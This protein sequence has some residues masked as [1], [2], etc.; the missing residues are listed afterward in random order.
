[1]GGGQSS[2]K[3]PLAPDNESPTHAT[4]DLSVTADAAR[5]KFNELDVDN[6]GKLSK[7]E[8]T[9]FCNWM[10][11][12]Y[13]SAN[14]KLTK[15]EMDLLKMRLMNIFDENDD[16]C[17]TFDEFKELYDEVV[18][19]VSLVVACESKFQ[20]FDRDKNGYLEKEEML[21][22][23][24]WILEKHQHFQYDSDMKKHVIETLV[25]KY[26]VNADCRLVN[27]RSRLTC[28]GVDF[29]CRVNM[30]SLFFLRKFAIGRV[31]Y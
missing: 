1:M 3:A 12:N 11:V 25:Q 6:S 22:L 2:F 16:G 5:L 9:E 18:R 8:L 10:Q 17:L 29:D 30:S 26:D 4:S 13:R 28:L 14:E 23:A 31:S 24:E 20:E 7:A 19:R 15:K 27:H 21:A